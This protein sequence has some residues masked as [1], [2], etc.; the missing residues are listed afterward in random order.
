MNQL[1][2]IK[3]IL[4]RHRGK[5]NKITS[6]EI[7]IEI[8]NDKEDDTHADTRAKILKCIKKYNL[9]VLADNTGYYYASTD[10]ELNNYINNLN[11]RIKAI[12]ERREIIIK[13]YEEA[14]K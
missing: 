9:P 10:D 14:N 6:A 5:Q 8:G 11:K 4:E 2:L 1:L 12:E 13:N 3:T 7:A